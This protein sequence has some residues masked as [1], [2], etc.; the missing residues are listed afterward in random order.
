MSRICC[1]RCIDAVRI[2]DRQFQL[3]FI[4][5]PHCTT[6][7]HTALY[8]VEVKTSDQL[9]LPLRRVAKCWIYKQVTGVLEIY[10]HA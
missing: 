8:N 9:R 5:S 4:S 10:R 1:I 3:G 6:T 2:H 7:T